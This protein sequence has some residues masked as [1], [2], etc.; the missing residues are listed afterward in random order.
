MKS[1]TRIFITVFILIQITVVPLFGI[2]LGTTE[3]TTL[4]GTI[5][6]WKWRCEIKYQEEEEV[7]ANQFVI[8]S[9][10]MIK[11]KLNGKRTALH[12]DIQ[13]FSRMLSIGAGINVDDL[14]EDEFLFFLPSS[15]L[16]GFKNGARLKVEGYSIGADETIVDANCASI[17]IDDKILKKLPPVWVDEADKPSNDTKKR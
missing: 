5:V 2:P 11:L 6:Q 16:E 13:K 8:P 9:H 15:R 1:I 10:Y 17:L 7:R 3:K 12:D 14:K 4:T